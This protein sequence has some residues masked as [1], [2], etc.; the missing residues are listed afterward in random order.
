MRGV[1]FRGPGSSD[2]FFRER[3]PTTICLSLNKHTTTNTKM[4]TTN[5]VKVMLNADLQLKHERQNN[6]D[7][8]DNFRK[9]NECTS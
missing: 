6:S 1:T 2:H 3:V 9:T 5:F 7:E 4:R 8:V